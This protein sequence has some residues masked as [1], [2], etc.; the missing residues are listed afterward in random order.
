M[1]K[2]KHRQTWLQPQSAAHS[3]MLHL[4][5]LILLLG[6]SALTLSPLTQFFSPAV[7][8]K[9]SV[10]FLNRAP[11]SVIIIIRYNR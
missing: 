7:P 2:L 10:W 3:H 11:S 8:A 9:A 4:P 5:A 6:T 1:Q